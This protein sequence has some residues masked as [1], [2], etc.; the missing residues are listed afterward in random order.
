MNKTIGA[1]LALLVAPASLA[2]EHTYKYELTPFAGFAT[3]GEFKDMATTASLVL[4]DSNSF[5]LIL[6][7][8]EDRLTSRGEARHRFEKRVGES[9]NRPGQ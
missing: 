6:N 3:G 9:R 4:D 1:C 2:Q 8:G 5:G 7:I